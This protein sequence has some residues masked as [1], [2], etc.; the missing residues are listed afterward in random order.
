MKTIR[1]L[2]LSGA[3]LAV[4]AQAGQSFNVQF[5]FRTPA[6][7]MPAGKYQT[8]VR[9]LATAQYIELRNVETKRSVILYPTNPV[10]DI[11]GHETPRLE[12]A[13]GTS[14]C[15]LKRL[16]RDGASGHD[17]RQKKLTPAEKE[18]L[19]NVRTETVAAE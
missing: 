7:D 8:E 10:T 18:R 17:F 16:W 2:L 14:G 5:P 3:A 6:G 13:C 19:A 4:A 11:R 15:D 9:Q 1:T 12:F